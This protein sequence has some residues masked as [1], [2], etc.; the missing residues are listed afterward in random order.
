MENVPKTALVYVGLDFIGDGLMKLPFVRAMRNALPETKI[1]WLAGKGSSVYNGILSPL[2]SDLLDEVID[3]A[4]IGSKFSE[5]FSSPLQERQFDLIIDTQRRVLT[6]LIIR[7]IPHLVFISGS[8]NFLFSSRS[9][10][11]GYKKPK[12]MIQQ[13]LNLLELATEKNPSIS[14]QLKIDDK[15]INTAS[16]F[17]PNGPKYVGFSPGA[18]GKKKCW[19]LESFIELAKRLESKS[20]KIVFLLG[21]EEKEMY[22][23]L[24]QKLPAALFPD[25]EEHGMQN[26]PL[27]SMAVSTRLSA[28]VSNDSGNMHMI[29]ASDI[30]L[31]VL[32]GPSSPEKFSPFQRKIET[33]CAK[34]FG[35]IE[36][37]RIPVES[38]QKKLNQLLND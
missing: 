3:N 27:Y 36:M 38:V 23:I 5:L 9:P 7:R 4:N 15:Y 20:V 26:G 30:P 22:P 32:Y 2:V 37:E 28:A 21:P 16:H 17:L 6:T 35:G 19:P 24:K 31:L 29:A 11:K 14:K 1:T 10:E 34:D 12:S 18:G 8:A 33:I 25:Q 13:M